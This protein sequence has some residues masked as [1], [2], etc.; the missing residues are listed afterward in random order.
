MKKTRQWYDRDNFWETFENI[1]FNQKRLADT[2][3]EVGNIIKL[4]D[5]REN[6]RI[7]DLCCGPGRHTLEFARQGFTISGVDRTLP[8][9]R[10]AK[11]RAQKEH[12]DIE[13]IQSDMRSFKCLD[14]FDVVLNLFT[15]FG[16]FGDAG[17]DQVV[18]ENIYESLK[19]GGKLLMEMMGKEV[20]ARIFRERDWQEVDGH[21]ILEERKLSQNWGWIESRWILFKE[22]KRVEQTIS[23]RLYSAAEL[24]TLL[25]KVGFSNIQIYGD[26]EGSEYDHQAKRLVVMAQKN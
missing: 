26:Y 14:S 18:V 12:L 19:P 6:S 16:Y 5:I 15:S 3:V 20:L 9:L 2:S 21:L 17:D 7:L 10:K 11:N 22:N 13:F 25:T 4:L 1:I 23:H 24:S 8:Y